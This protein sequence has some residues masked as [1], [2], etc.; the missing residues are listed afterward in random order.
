MN[1]GKYLQLYSEDL[2]LKN[3][4]ENTRENYISQVKT[5]LE[6]FNGSAT[7][8]SEISERAIKEWLLLA[9][10]TNTLKQRISA[11]KLFYELTGKQPLK[12]KHIEYPRASKKLPIVLSADEI[13][14]MFDACENLKHR[15]I[16][17]LLYACGLRV[18]ELI[19]LKWENI[20]RSRQ[21]INIIAAKGNKDRQVQLPI[22]LIKLLENYWYQYKSKEYVINGQN[23]LKYSETSV[24]Q[25]IK[26]LAKKAKIN[27]RV[28]THLIRHCCFTHMVEAGTDINLIQRLAGHNSVKT[29]MIYCHISENL[30]SKIKSP[31]EA[32][33]LSA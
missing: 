10:S 11:V 18:S 17:A 24:L 33:K 26:Q 12:F 5:F 9:K 25:I 16:L 6:H 8:P 32:I 20:D 7:K 28:Y 21:I 15:A 27:K 1:I 30:I 4:S 2:R 29:T 19:N 31:I 13:Q 22:A 14:R 23:S 3:Y